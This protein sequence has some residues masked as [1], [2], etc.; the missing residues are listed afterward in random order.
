MTTNFAR[1]SNL[2]VS[3][4][5]LNYCHISL[6]LSLSL[7]RRLGCG[8][9]PTTP[10]HTRYASVQCSCSR[11]SLSFFLSAGHRGRPSGLWPA[12]PPIVLWSRL[13]LSLVL[14]CD[15][16]R[17][18]RVVTPPP[19]AVRAATFSVPQRSESIVALCDWVRGRF[20]VLRNPPKQVWHE[21]ETTRTKITVST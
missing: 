15:W 2:K 21:A 5:R 13:S 14:A 12:L 3:C 16:L 6:S 10:A 17:G 11:L 7:A 4:G 19:Q 9:A 20:P 18:V 1:Y 8:V